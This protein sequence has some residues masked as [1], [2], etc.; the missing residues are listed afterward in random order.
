M[1]KAES[2]ACTVNSTSGQ[3]VASVRVKACKTVELGAHGLDKDC[4]LPKRS[5]RV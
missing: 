3:V 4:G 2:F 5:S 1:V